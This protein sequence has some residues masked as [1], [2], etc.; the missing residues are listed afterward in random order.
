MYDAMFWGMWLVWLAVWIVMARSVKAT[1][2]S[3]SRAQR[4]THIIPLTLAFYL[5]AAPHVPWPA[6][7]A[8]FLPLAYWPA[9]LGL[10]LTFAGLGIAIWAR[11][12]L[13]GNW[14]GEVTL[15]AGHELI[16]T[17]P[18]RYARHPIYTGLLLALLG[19]G[20]AGGEWRGLLAVALAAGSFWWKLRR[21]E[22]LMRSEFG[23]AYRNYAARVKALV[24]GVV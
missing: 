17:G 18:Y 2:L 4:L 15:K 20:I 16:T 9:N 8:R 24:P 21:E 22:A 13:A 3:E 14:S 6:L 5:L 1:A 23:A 10:V 12:W 11:L 19:S 7:E